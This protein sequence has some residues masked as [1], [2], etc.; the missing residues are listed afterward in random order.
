[1]VVKGWLTIVV[2]KN[3]THG[4]LYSPTA[5]A[6]WNGLKERFDKVNKEA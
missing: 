5:F 2:A 3:L 1:M 6:I 4:L